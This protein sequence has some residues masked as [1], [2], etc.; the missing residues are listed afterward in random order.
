MHKHK[1]SKL[2]GKE[3]IK[4]RS[5]P[6]DDRPLLIVT[7]LGNSILTRDSKVLVKIGENTFTRK[8]VEDLREGEKVLYEKEGIDYEKE[9]E[10]IDEL[11]GQGRKYRNSMASLF[12]QT[13]KAHTPIFRVELL[14][15]IFSRPD[16]W[17][18]ELSSDPGL[19]KGVIDNNGELPAELGKMAAET[20]HKRLCSAL[21]EGTRPVTMEHIENGWLT[22]KVIAPRGFKEVFWALGKHASGLVDL[23]GTPVFERD[24]WMYRAMRLSL[25]LRLST[26]MKGNGKGIAAEQPPK[27]PDTPYLDEEARRELDQI[28]E[29]FA[30]DV[31]TKFA[32]ASVVSVKPVKPTAMAE[33][34]GLVLRKGVVVKK[35]DTFDSEIIGIHELEKRIAILGEVIGRAL[36]VYRYK[37]HP[38]YA[39]KQDGM[40]EDKDAFAF[41][42]VPQAVFEKIGYEGREEGLKRSME[43]VKRAGI[44]AKDFFTQYLGPEIIQ[45]SREYGDEA[46]KLILSGT[47]DEWCGLE[48]GTILGAFKKVAAYDSALPKESEYMHYLLGLLTYFGHNGIDSEA[49]RLNKEIEIV[50]EIIEKKGFNG[51]FKT[52]R[53]AIREF[54]EHYGGLS[55][56]VE[57]GLITEWEAEIVSAGISEHQMESIFWKMETNMLNSSGMP[58]GQREIWMEFHRKTHICVDEK[59]E[60]LERMGMREAAGKIDMALRVLSIRLRND[61]SKTPSD[62]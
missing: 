52:T 45:R 19:I 32:V 14:R 27:N 15:G 26:I 55:L 9:R 36:D 31:D 25:S 37:C 11:L 60:L 49:K 54:T 53:S 61:F 35:P 3:R 1:K 51:H 4:I 43:R 59:E 48:R 18:E 50:E 13:S 23:L 38:E 21:D 34:N 24:Y 30:E 20:I 6:I 44:D 39:F 12:F 28:V 58:A 10:K 62:A 17:P 47:L 8:A 33:K 56:L 41:S 22:G 2:H 40:E 57:N 42:F 46:Y 7:S 5:V 16:E 29:F